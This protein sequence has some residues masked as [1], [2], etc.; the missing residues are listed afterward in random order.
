MNYFNTRHLI[1]YAQQTADAISSV[2]NLQ[3]TIVDSDVRRVAGT[4]CFSLTLD[5][6]LSPN[7][8]FNE[9]IRTG[10][11]CLIEDPGR[12]ATCQDCAE[13]DNCR[14]KA[15]LLVPVSLNGQI[16]GAIGIAAMNEADKQ[17]MIDHISDFTT[18]MEKMADMLAAKVESNLNITKLSLYAKRFETVVNAFQDGIL[19]V[20]AEGRL[21]H[22]NR[23]AELILGEELGQHMGM[24]IRGI[25]QCVFFDNALETKMNLEH[26]R[27]S[28][29]VRNRVYP[30]VMSVKTIVIEEKIEGFVA[31]FEEVG[32]SRKKMESVFLTQT[33]YSFDDIIGESD[34]I[35]SCIE[36]AKRV[37]KSNSSILIL[38]ESG[39]GKEMFARAIHRNSKRSRH[40]FVAI[41]C[42]AIPDALLESELFGY[43]GG[44]FTGANKEGNP[45]KF[46]IAD[47]GTVFL[48]EI[49]DMPLHL[50]AKLLRVLQEREVVRIGDSHPI[51]IDVR[52]IAATNRN[53]EEMISENLFRRDLYYRINV[54]PIAIP[55]LVERKEDIQVLAMFLL[56]KHA[57]LTGKNIEGIEADALRILES[58][59]W[60]GNVR[61]LENVIE[62]AINMETDKKI[63][64]ENLPPYL[65]EETPASCGKQ[66]TKGSSL[67]EAVNLKERDRIINALQLFDDSTNGKRECASYLGISLSTLYRKLKEYGIN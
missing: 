2:L 24:D 33:R 64:G 36:M 3:V 29:K 65:S 40:N 53:L 10:K 19:L 66:E 43:K 67:K 6:V 42:S 20:D 25:V 61:E 37:S 28:V 62:Y 1:D 56:K 22:Y 21:I 63:H 51:P 11:K 55:P 44:A 7:Y 54:I 12:T 32:I 18:F 23:Q 35:K 38:G 47:G 9:V 14:E 58:H 8:V 17:R 41:N 34:K 27:V 45:G 30:L 5:K 60:P 31:F 13:R 48:D 26:Q 15:T 46:E 39:T 16:I 50:Q 49:G 59:H 4:G 52:V 57:T